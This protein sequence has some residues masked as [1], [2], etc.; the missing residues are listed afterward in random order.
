MSLDLTILKQ[1]LAPKFALS[2]N[3]QGILQL[4]S[5]TENFRPIYCDFTEKKFL[6]RCQDKKQGLLK[7][8]GLHKKQG[9]TIL[10]ATAG[11]GKDSFVL[12]YHGANVIALER[13]PIIFALLQDGL[14]RLNQFSFPRSCVGMQTKLE[15]S[16]NYLQQDLS[17]QNIDIIYLDPMYPNRKK[18]ALVKKE[19]QILQTLLGQDDKA[20]QLLAMALKQKSKIVVKRPRLGVYLNGQLPS[21]QIIE[22]TIR[23]D[24]Y[25]A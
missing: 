17:Q 8:V 11:L 14:Q 15:N 5:N 25:L 6:K 1:Q 7:A 16:L 4:A 12:A 20:D 3:K 18:S 23:F 13:H 24:I 19:M 9:L 21:Y 2:Y 10:D 22:K